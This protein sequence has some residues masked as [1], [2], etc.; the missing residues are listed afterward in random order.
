MTS[1]FHVFV[2]LMVILVLSLPFVSLAQQNT[3]QQQAIADAERDVS[4]DINSSIWFLGGCLAGIPVL[5]VANIYQPTPPSSNLLGKSPE[6]V[7][8]YI[9]TYHSK[10]K[11]IQSKNALA[12]CITGAAVSS[13]IITF[14]YNYFLFGET[15]L[16]QVD[17][18]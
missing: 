8:Y 5:I 4:G 18:P 2:C 9:D 6:Y 7:A 10:S 11:S 12:G 3:I 16:T 15:S 1:I 14:Y 17:T 13:C